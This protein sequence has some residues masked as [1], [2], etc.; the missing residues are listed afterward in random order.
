MGQLWKWLLSKC[1]IETDQKSA[2]VATLPKVFSLPS[3]SLKFRDCFFWFEKSYKRVSTISTPVE[4]SQKRFFRRSLESALMA[5]I[6]LQFWSRFYLPLGFPFL[7]KWLNSRLLSIRSKK[8]LSGDFVDDDFSLF[9]KHDG[10]WKTQKLSF[11]CQ[12]SKNL[13]FSK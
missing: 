5:F 6:W 4:K 12:E 11:K 3:L 13:R 1:L 8:C 9:I 7:M 2:N 10:D